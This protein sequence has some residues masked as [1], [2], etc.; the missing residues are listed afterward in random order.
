MKTEAESGEYAVRERDIESNGFCA[1]NDH[2]AAT[3][4]CKLTPF[5]A[6]QI[7]RWVRVSLRTVV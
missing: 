2:T 3:H 7:K 6:V 4:L 5:N 1:N